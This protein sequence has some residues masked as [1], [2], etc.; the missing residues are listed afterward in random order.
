MTTGD[1]ATLEAMLANGW[2]LASVTDSAKKTVL[3][4]AAQI[5]NVPAVELLLK[6]GAPVD[7]VTSSK[8]TPLHMAVRN[9]RLELCLF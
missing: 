4:R 7:A 5:G 6:A 3:H 9:G 8:E 1:N 2:E